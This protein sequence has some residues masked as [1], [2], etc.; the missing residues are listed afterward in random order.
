MFP[1]ST[2][3][4]GGN[5][6]QVLFDTSSFLKWWFVGKKTTEPITSES[7]RSAASSKL[8]LVETSQEELLASDFSV[9]SMGNDLLSD[10]KSSNSLKK[11]SATTIARSS[12]NSPLFLAGYMEFDPMVAATRSHTNAHHNRRSSWFSRSD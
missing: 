3:R 8:N 6:G 1:K 2:F 5:D 9:T 10:L 7:K 11:S 4:G 12:I